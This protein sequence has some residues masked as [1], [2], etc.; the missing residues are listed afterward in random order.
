M[1]YR[2]ESPRIVEDV[3]KKSRFI[4]II[5][6]VENESDAARFLAKLAVEYAD[7]NHIAFAYR[8]RSEQGFVCRFHDAGEPAGTAGKPIF[9]HLEGK[10]LM[11][12]MIA[13]VR[14]FGGIKLGAGGLVRAYG[15]AA[16]KVIEAADIVEHIDLVRIRLTLP[17][18]QMQALEYRLKQLNG[19]ILEQNFT[20]RVALLVEVPAAEKEALLQSL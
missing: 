19:R 17:Y 16:K 20:D 15:N 14:Y 7:A 2:V 13:V 12:V 18:N 6:P 11:N 3:I 1:M 9:Q 4:A 8:I 10:R 5:E